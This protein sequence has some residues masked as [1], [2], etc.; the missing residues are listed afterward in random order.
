MVKKI[1]IATRIYISPDAQP[2]FLRSSTL[3][4][5]PCANLANFIA[6]WIFFTA[7]KALSIIVDATC[8]ASTLS[9]ALW[10]IIYAPLS[11]YVD[12]YQEGIT[13]RLGSYYLVIYASPFSYRVPPRGA[14]FPTKQISRLDEAEDL[15]LRGLLFWIVHRNPVLNGNF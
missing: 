3:L 15:L 11:G 14:R 2:L 13:T 8:S 4:P 6:A 9:S 12:R 1:E 7:S 5:S 10:Y